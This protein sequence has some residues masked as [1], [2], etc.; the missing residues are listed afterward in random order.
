MRR[1]KGIGDW[2]VNKASQEID[3]GNRRKITSRREWKQF[4]GDTEKGRKQ[5][6][7]AE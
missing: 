1:D 4:E 5:Q 2:P 7:F 3:N 6:R